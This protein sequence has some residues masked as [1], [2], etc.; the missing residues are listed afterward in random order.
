MVI[1][2]SELVEHSWPRLSSKWL[3][4]FSGNIELLIYPLLLVYTQYLTYRRHFLKIEDWPHLLPFFVGLSWLGWCYWFQKPPSFDSGIPWEWGVF[5]LVKGIFFTGYFL[6]IVRT[7]NS[8]NQQMAS[9]SMQRSLL[10]K[11]SRRFVVFLGVVLALMY[12]IFFINYLGIYQLGAADQWGVL[13]LVVVI[14]LM[15]IFMF[16]NQELLTDQR[17]PDVRLQELMG[18]EEYYWDQLIQL[19]SREK[20]HLQPGVDIK[21]T[22]R[23]MGL[24]PSQMSYLLKHQRISFKEMLNACRVK[25]VLFKIQTGEHHRKTLLAIAL[26]SGFNSKASFNRIFRDHTGMTPSEYSKQKEVSKP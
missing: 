9:F 18:R 14:Y 3:T 20:I 10:I 21:Q 5:M 4:V 8:V 19:V 26:E 17:V 13:I 1:L 16:R 15:G 12:L 7:L 25:D 11:H 23:L 2:F 6:L 24:K 22:A